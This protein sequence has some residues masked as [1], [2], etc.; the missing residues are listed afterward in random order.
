MS[1]E[2][3]FLDPKTRRVTQ[4]WVDGLRPFVEAHPELQHVD[5]VVQGGVGSGMLMAN[6]AKGLF[7]GAFYVGTDLAEALYRRLP[8]QRGL[9][10]EEELIRITEANAHPASGMERAV[11]RAN[12]FDGALIRDIAGHVGATSPLLVSDDALYALLGRAVNPWEKKRTEDIFPIDSILSAEMPY[13]GH[14]HMGVDW[15][16]E[17]KTS[18]SSSY[19]LLERE[20]HARGWT[21]QRG[22][23]ELLLLRP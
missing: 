20:A 3:S 5:L 15:E 13:V 8:R 1:A 11:I 19:Y 18:L 17:G 10:A 7:P 9:I 2:L 4:E 22:D 12:C 6:V 16:D 23:L 14:I 21:T